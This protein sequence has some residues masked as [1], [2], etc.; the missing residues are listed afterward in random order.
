MSAD[1][2][3]APLFTNHENQRPEGFF[4]NEPLTVAKTKIAKRKG[5]V[6]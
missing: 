6:E 3:K 1:P 2:E 5:C 4:I